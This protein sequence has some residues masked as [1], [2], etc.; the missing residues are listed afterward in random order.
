[1]DDIGNGH[2]P[3]HNTLNEAATEE[4]VQNTPAVNTDD[5]TVLNNNPADSNDENNVDM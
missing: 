3:A 2:I 4:P 5:S 1:M